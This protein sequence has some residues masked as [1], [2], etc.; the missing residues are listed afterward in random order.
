MVWGVRYG[1]WGEATVSGFW[2]LVSGFGS[3]AS[4]LGF[5]VS[6]LGFRGEGVPSMCPH[7]DCIDA[8]LPGWGGREKSE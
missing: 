7:G 3:R 6:G 5:L 8:T 1:V 2:F 4:G